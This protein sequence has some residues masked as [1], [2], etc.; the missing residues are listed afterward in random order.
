M[1]YYLAKVASY[2]LLMLKSISAPDEQFYNQMI[3]NYG[4]L[5]CPSG[6]SFRELVLLAFFFTVVE[7]CCFL[8][9]TD[10]NGHWLSKFKQI[11]NAI[12]KKKR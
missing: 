7:S 9:L 4:S 10:R 5:H 12:K 11:Q 8:F 1:Q 2:L 6:N 3:H